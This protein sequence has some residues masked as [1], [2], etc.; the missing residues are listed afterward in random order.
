[1][2]DDL[3]KEIQ[4]LD[5]LAL[6]SG[7][8]DEES[9]S[10]EESEEE[11]EQE[12]TDV[13]LEKET[14][15]SL[16]YRSYHPT[17]MD[18]CTEFADSE[19][20]LIDGDALLRQTLG[21]EG[22]GGMGSQLVTLHIISLLERSLANFRDRGGEFNLV[23]FKNNQARW[24]P[25]VP[26]LLRTAVILHFRENTNL[27]VFTNFEDPFD[28]DFQQYVE[29]EKP[30]FLLSAAE[31]DD[32][33]D[34]VYFLEIKNLGLN[35]A[36]IFGMQKTLVQI[37]CW[38]TM[39]QPSSEAFARHVRY[40][41]GVW[42][43]EQAEVCEQ[44]LP[45][46]STTATASSLLVAALADCKEPEERLVLGAMLVTATLQRHLGLLERVVPGQSLRMDPSSALLD[47]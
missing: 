26:L 34:A 44:P 30:S 11:M 21:K 32:L 5:D 7:D 24:T 12:M 6:S 33:Q 1:M 39:C 35:F 15:G 18:L 47:R 25:G 19:E 20:F 22:S 28:L 36:D 42:R 9:S 16:F 8:E 41:H 29:T 43:S 3:P 31:K 13:E 38:Y 46:L 14:I 17:F 45:S 40:L 10:G 4:D 37:F 2:S 27:T 23:F